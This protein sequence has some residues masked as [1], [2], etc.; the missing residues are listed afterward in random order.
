MQHNVSEAKWIAMFRE[1][2]AVAI[3]HIKISLLQKCRV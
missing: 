1:I 2:N 3:A